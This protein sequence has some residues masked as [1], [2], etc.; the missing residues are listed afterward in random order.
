MAMVHGDFLTT[1]IPVG[2]VFNRSTMCAALRKAGIKTPDWKRIGN[3]LCFNQ[4]N[5]RSITADIFFASWH[6]YAND[7]QPSW[8]QLAQALERSGS[9]K[10]AVTYVQEKE[11]MNHII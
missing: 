1:I 6:A 7:F 2:Q 9:S 10:Q 5:P 3:A 11:G 8:N 4:E